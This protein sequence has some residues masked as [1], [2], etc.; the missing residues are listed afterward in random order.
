MRTRGRAAVAS[1]ILGGL[2]TVET[3]V[4]KAVHTPPTSCHLLSAFL[5]YFSIC[6]FISTES[7]EVFPRRMK[8]RRGKKFLSSS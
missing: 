5:S 6:L 8:K 1:T 7:K 4:L 2:Q 3:Q